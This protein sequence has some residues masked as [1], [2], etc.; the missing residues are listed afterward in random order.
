VQ[1]NAI[2]HGGGQWRTFADPESNEFD[3]V[4]SSHERRR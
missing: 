1:L 2:E 4:A 3:L